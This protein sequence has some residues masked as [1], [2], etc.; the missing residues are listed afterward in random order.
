MEEAM[1]LPISIPVMP[2]ASA[3]T[4]PPEDPPGVLDGSHGLLVVPY[5]ALKVCPSASQ[6]G[7]LV[8]PNIT[9]PATSQRSTASAFVLATLSLKSGEPQV[10][11]SP[12]TSK[13]SFTVIGTP[14]KGPH[15]SPLVRARSAAFARRRAFGMSVTMMALSAGLKRS[16]RPR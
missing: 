15:T 4:A 9:A 11:G 8:L 2:A 6:S 5:T 14:C 13:A 16:T 7:T 3:D 10:E 1:S 12:L